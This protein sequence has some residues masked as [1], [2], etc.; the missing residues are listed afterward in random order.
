MNAVLSRVVLSALLGL[1][2][3]VAATEPA[4]KVV[5]AAPPAQEAG[6]A[7]PALLNYTFPRLQDESPQPLCQYRGKVVLVVNTASYCG[8]TGQYDGLEKMYAKYKDQ[9]L[10]VLG[11]PSNDFGGQEPGSNKEIADF[12]RLTYGVKFPMLGK[13]DVVGSATNP[14]YKQLASIT[15]EKPKWNFHKYLIDRSG[16]KV[17]SFPSSTAPDSKTFVTA[18]E[19]ALAE[20]P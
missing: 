19:R 8:F 18:V 17:L 14:L 20:R 10:V 13:S 1:A 4:A 7:C 12:C 3:P 6:Q 11:F 15:G 9:G 16:Q 5:P 2:L